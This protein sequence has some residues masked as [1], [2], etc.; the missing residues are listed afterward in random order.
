MKN[1]IQPSFFHGLIS[2]LAVLA[3]AGCNL[4]G[5]SNA[6]A[7]EGANATA[8]AIFQTLEA[9]SVQQTVPP[10]DPAQPPAATEPPQQPAQPT[11]QPGQPTVAGGAV[12]VVATAN[13]NCRSGPSKKYPK[14]SN[15]GVELRANASGKDA[16]GEWLYVQ[17]SKKVSES[18]WVSLKTV[19][20]E[21]DLNS[22]PVVEPM[23]LEAAQTQAAQ[24]VVPQAPV[25]PVNQTATP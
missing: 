23:T 2:L 20:V 17:N 19:T 4:S 13:T 14:I 25:A 12:T 10:A 16:T 9:P 5:N 18:C 3:L 21:G 22:L 15:L 11:V 1:Q 6:P 24:T 8:T 7:D